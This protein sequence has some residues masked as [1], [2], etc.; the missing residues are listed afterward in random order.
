MIKYANIGL[1]YVHIILGFLIMGFIIAVLSSLLPV[2]LDMIA[3]LNEPRPRIAFLKVNI[4]TDPNENYFMH[5][6]ACL[7]LMI[8]TDY[9]VMSILFAFLI[10]EYHIFGIFNI[11]K[12]RLRLAT[13]EL[14]EKKEESY[15]MIISAI[16]LHQDCLKIVT[17]VDESFNILF[18]FSILELLIFLSIIPVAIL[19]TANFYEL[20]RQSTFLVAVAGALFVLNWP[21]QLLVNES[22]DLFLSTYMGEW[23]RLS[24]ESKILLIII[25]YR[26]IQP[27]MFTAGTFCTLNYETFALIMKSAFSYMTFLNSVRQ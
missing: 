20:A 9:I 18:G 11:I 24:K 8:V 17:T 2:Y 5:Y 25:R 19:E 23:Y 4:I 15:D 3:P 7:V 10:F 13:T 16:K 14:A 1:R 12:Y 22:E 21:G 6:F 26:C 27:C